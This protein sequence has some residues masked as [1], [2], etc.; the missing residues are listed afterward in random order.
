L[1]FCLLF[2]LQYRY[3]ISRAHVHGE[4]PRVTLPLLLPP[5]QPTPP[6][7]VGSVLMFRLN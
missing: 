5:V 2:V 7:V 3:Y 1:G 6:R 4:R